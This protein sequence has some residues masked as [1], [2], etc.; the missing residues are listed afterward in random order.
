M[1][2]PIKVAVTYTYGES[3][4]ITQCHN[5]IYLGMLVDKHVISFKA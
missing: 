5:T 3:V 4:G 2:K 1:Q